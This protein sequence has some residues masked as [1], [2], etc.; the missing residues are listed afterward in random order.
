[1][2]FQPEFRK[3]GTFETVIWVGRDITKLTLLVQRNGEQARKMEQEMARL[4]GLNLIGRLAA[5]IGHEIRNPMTTI[6]G[7]LQLLSDQET[8]VKRREFFRIMIEE[9]DRAG[10]IIS[11][12]LSLAKN[13][14]TELKEGSLNAIIES[15]HPLLQGAAFQCDK[16]VL[17]VLGKDAPVLLAEDEIRQLILNLV[18]NGLEAAPIHS[19]VTVKTNMEND[20]L[21]LQIQDEGCG[22]PQH[23]LE[24]IGK[25]FFTTKENGTGLGLAVCY[26]IAKR[27]RAVIDVKSSATGTT[28]SVRFPS[29]SKNK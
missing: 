26:S 2:S 12:Y 7:F 22:I 3:D 23:V 11:E 5:T 28:F 27:H 10:T 1:M 8:D 29:L 20:W 15:I 24:Q 16:N 21:V 4:S 19:C 6:R 25:P 17:C 13:K 14:P 18:K 9:L